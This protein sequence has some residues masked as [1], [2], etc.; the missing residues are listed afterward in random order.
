MALCSSLEG[1]VIKSDPNDYFLPKSLSEP[2]LGLCKVGQNPKLPISFVLCNV[3][4][5]GPVK[6]M[7]YLKKQTK[8]DTNL[9]PLIFST[10]QIKI[11]YICMPLLHLI[12]NSVP[13]D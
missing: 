9:I 6:F 5:L 12:L 4:R 13:K 8:T 11:S 1:P 3:T 7:P 2:G 10:R